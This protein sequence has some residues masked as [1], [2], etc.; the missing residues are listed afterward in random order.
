MS[1]SALVRFSRRI[2]SLR[3]TLAGFVLLGLGAFATAAGTARGRWLI[4]VPLFLLA[5]NLLAALLTC[6]CFRRQPALY[7]FHVC[8]LLLAILLGV[9]QLT[10][11]TGHFEISEGQGFDPA[12]VVIDSRGEWNPGLPIV[13]AF[14][15]GPIQVGYEPGLLRRGTSSRV[16][17]FGDGEGPP[18]DIADGKPLVAEG[19]RFYATHNKGFSALLSWRSGGGEV[20][21][22]TVHFPSYPRQALDQVMQWRTPQGTPVEL[23][24]E[25]DPLPQDA[26]VLRAQRAGGRLWVRARDGEDRVLQTGQSLALPGGVVRLEGFGMWMGYRV[27]YDPTLPWIFA[28]ALLAVSMLAW[29]LWSRLERPLARLEPK[30]LKAQRTGA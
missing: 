28:C 27:F 26:W 13:N 4:A 5:L 9:G 19:Y 29:H 6:S 18:V 15:Q 16:W 25:P 24:L 23:R 30:A 21:R 17:L 14:R 22:G 3:L 12:A 11:L 7:A 1:E 20:L 2:A 8:L 10:R